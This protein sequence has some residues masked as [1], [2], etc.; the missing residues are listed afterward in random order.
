MTADIFQLILNYCTEL[1]AQ[2]IIF[3]FFLIVRFINCSFRKTNDIA[4]RRIYFYAF[5]F[6]CG[7]LYVDHRNVFA[8]DHT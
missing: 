8:R 1:C 6:L 5:A 3:N 7:V 4:G 2:T